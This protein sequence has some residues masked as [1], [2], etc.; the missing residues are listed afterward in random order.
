MTHFRNCT[1]SDVAPAW[2]CTQ[3]QVHLYLY[4]GNRSSDIACSGCD[5]TE[6]SFATDPV[7]EGSSYDVFLE[8]SRFWIQRVLVPIVTFIGVIGNSLTIVIMTRRRMRSSTNNYLAALATVDTLYL[9]GGFTLSLKHYEVIQRKCL[10]VY[11]RCFPILILLTDTCSNSSVWLTATFTVERYIAVCHPIKS[12]VLCTESRAKKAIMGVLLFCFAL[13]LPTPFEYALVE[14]QDPV[15]NVTRVSLNYSEFGRN[16]MYKKTYYWTT[17]V[18]FTLVPFCLL[19]VFNALLVR[20]VHISRKQ[21]S[22]MILRTDPS[23]DSQESKITIMLIAVVILFFFCQ[24]PTAITL[25]YTSIGNLQEGSEQEKLVFILGNVFNFLMSLNAAGNFVLYCLL[26]Q[27][28][29]R[30]LLQVLCPIGALVR[31]QSLSQ[32]TGTSI[33]QSEDR[34][35]VSIRT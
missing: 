34:T 17:V 11:L 19:A 28:Y 9:L 18:V 26:S 16:E 1:T 25:L 4:D 22:R 10:S 14:E 32:C 33:I 7:A 21:R 23:R 2:M 27:K 6:A 3:G 5:S 15:T 31:L 13:A 30:T 20:S 35:T 24:L 8:S 12:R 29:R